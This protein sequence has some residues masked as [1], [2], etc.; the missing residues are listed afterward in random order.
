MRKDKLTLSKIET[1]RRPGVLNDGR[2]LYLYVTAGGAKSWCFRFTLG[3]RRRTMGLGGIDKRDLPAAR[4]RARECRE[5]VEHGIDPI[6]Y[7]RGDRRLTGAKTVLTFKKAALAYIEA[8]KDGWSAA[9]VQKWPYQFE[10]YVFP[11]I[12]ALP[13]QEVNNTDLVLKV[14]EPIWTTLPSTASDLRGRL[15]MVINWAKFRGYCTGENAARWKGHLELHLPRPGQVRPVRH[16]PAL[17]YRDV[18]GFLQKLRQ[19]HGIVAMALEFTLLT[20]GRQK[21][22]RWARWPEFDLDAGIWTIPAERMKMRREH[23][24]A[25]NEPALALLRKVAPRKR[26]EDDFVFPG[27]KT[28]KPLTQHVMKTRMRDMGYAGIATAHGFRSSFKDWATEQTNFSTEAVEL[29]LAHTV[30]NKVEAAYRRGDLLEK[31]R[32]LSKAW[33]DFCLGMPPP[34]TSNLIPFPRP[35]ERATQT[36]PVAASNSQKQPQQRQLRPIPLAAKTASLTAR[37]PQNRRHVPPT[38][39]PEQLSLDFGSAVEQ[40]ASRPEGRPLPAAV[41][42][43]VDMQPSAQDL[44]T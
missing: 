23:R 33:G 27:L 14:L 11:Q 39:D 35:D 32:L 10:L 44:F 18:P 38:A 4:E 34:A 20:V 25:L 28:G 37:S 9:T 42:D 13:M 22:T 21:E 40:P 30:G 43:N 36:A 16:Y 15:E 26:S 7:R 17:P 31:R 8:H 29:A 12:G 19:Q 3:G 2:G 24:V 6:D 41:P 1:A 5:L